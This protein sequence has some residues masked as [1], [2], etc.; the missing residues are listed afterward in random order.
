MGVC[1]TSGATETGNVRIAPPD[2]RMI[3]TGGTVP[4]LGMY[5]KGRITGN[6]HGDIQMM[7]DTINGMLAA[8]P[9]SMRMNEGNI[10]A[11]RAEMDA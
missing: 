10:S 4:Y 2:I 3:K 11:K 5:S 8:D 7:H 6:M 1:C 9:N